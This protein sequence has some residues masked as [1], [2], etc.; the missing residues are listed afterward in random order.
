MNTGVDPSQYQYIAY[1]AL[2]LLTAPITAAAIYSAARTGKGIE[3]RSLVRLLAAGIG[4]MISNMFELLAPTEASTLFF[5]RATYLFS[6][7]SPV[8]SILFGLAVTGHKKAA[9]SLKLIAALCVIPTIT[10]LLVWTGAG[11]LVWA[12]IKYN[13]AIGLPIVFATY[14]PWFYVHMA[15]TYAPHPRLRA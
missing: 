9:T 5:A 1:I 8:F 12:S 11:G 6:A 4:L 13:R 2:V 10:V 7:S 3:G 14:G 15:Y